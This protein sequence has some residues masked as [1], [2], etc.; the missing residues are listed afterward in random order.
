M[1]MESLPSLLSAAEDFCQFHPIKDNVHVSSLSIDG[2]MWSEKL[3]HHSGFHL[4]ALNFQF[5]FAL[6]VI[7]SY[8]FAN[9]LSKTKHTDL[10]VN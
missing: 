2:S 7:M 1:K 5:Q 8:K 4:I 6:L 9:M 10:N 3:T